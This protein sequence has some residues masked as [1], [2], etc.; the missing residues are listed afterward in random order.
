M[1]LYGGWHDFPMDSKSYIEDAIR[2][3]DFNNLYTSF[4]NDESLSKTVL[5]DFE[6]KI[7]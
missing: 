7:S 4:K 1:N 5:I 6:K 3:G 2:N